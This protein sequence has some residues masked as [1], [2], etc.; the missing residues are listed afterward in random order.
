MPK[1]SLMLTAAIGLFAALPAQAQKVPE[2][3]APACAADPLFQQLDFASGHWDVLAPDGTKRTEVKMDKT[4]NGCAIAEDWG[5]PGAPTGHGIGLF[6]Y[7]RVLKTWTYSW[8]SDRGAATFFY[9]GELIAPG[10][11]QF[12]TERSTPSGGKRLRHWSLILKPDGTVHE[13]SV[14]TE[15]GGKTWIPEIDLIWKKK[16]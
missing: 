15:D 10:N 6:T 13:L 1:Y 9:K 8:A 12:T 16:S 3:E 2:P 7:S 14:G 5:T 11:M 4:L